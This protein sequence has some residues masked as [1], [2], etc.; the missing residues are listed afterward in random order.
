M[1]IKGQFTT[2]N[3]YNKANR[4]NKFGGAS[5]MKQNKAIAYYQMLRKPKLK[6]PCK[7]RFT[8]YVKNQKTDPD[9]TAFCKK[10]ILDAMVQAQVI[11]DDTLKHIK[12]FIDDFVVSNE[13]GVKI[14]RV[15]K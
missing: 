11:P 12:G 9:N 10:Y 3:D 8:W 4:S 5:I 6:T 13:T 15:E 2:L 14:E 7:I 1:F